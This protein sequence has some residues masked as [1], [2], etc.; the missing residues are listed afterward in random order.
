VA[1]WNPKRR[2]S[3]KRHGRGESTAEESSREPASIGWRMRCADLID[4]DSQRG[5]VVSA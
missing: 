4:N 3:W 5:S 1:Y 2:W